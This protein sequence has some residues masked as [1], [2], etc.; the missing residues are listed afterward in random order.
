MGLTSRAGVVPLN[1]VADVAGPMARTV[2]DAAAVFNVVVGSDPA[3]TV[4]APADSKR[5]ADYTRSSS[6]AHSRAR[7]SA[8][9]A[10][11]TSARHSIQEVKASDSR[12][13]GRAARGGRD[14]RRCGARVDSLD[15]IQRRQQG[16]CNRFRA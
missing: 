2:A 1:A 10:R 13:D 12:A 6:A 3:D 5:E 14:H 15:A 7:V 9:C 8:S 16:S 4:T 11:R